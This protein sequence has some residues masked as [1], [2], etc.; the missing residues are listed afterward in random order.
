MVLHVA[1]RIPYDVVRCHFTEISEPKWVPPDERRCKNY[2]ELSD[3][4]R[5][6]HAVRRVHTNCGS[7]HFPSAMNTTNDVNNE[8]DVDTTEQDTTHVTIRDRNAT[9][10]T[11]PSESRGEIQQSHD[12]TSAPTEAV[13]STPANMVQM[14]ETL[15]E[16]LRVIPLMNQQLNHLTLQVQ[17]GEERNRQQLSLRQTVCCNS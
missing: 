12:S 13:E 6:R 9:S 14:M 11:T 17:Q 3:K 16:T 10:D 15:Q 8:G 1:C 4:I 2:Y 5:V 7:M